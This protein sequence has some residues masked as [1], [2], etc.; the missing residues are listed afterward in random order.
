[1]TY[2]SGYQSPNTAGQSAYSPFN[3]AQAPQ[4]TP[5]GQYAGYPPAVGGDNPFP[6]QNGSTL[7]ADT[8]L[9]PSSPEEIDALSGNIDSKIAE[10]RRAFSQPTAPAVPSP[11]AP[12]GAAPI[13]QEEMNWALALENKVKTE[14][15]QPNA[16]ETAQY[17]QIYAKLQAAQAGQQA[18]QNVPGPTA[19][20]TPA[21]P[22]AAPKVSDEEISWALALEQKVNSGHQPTAEET[23]RY[24][25][26]FSRL[27]ASEQPAQAPAG[28]QA[29]A[30]P[31]SQEEMNWAL[32][33]ENKVKTEGYQPNAQETARYEQIYAKLQAAQQAA[34]TAP[35][36]PGA[37][38]APGAPATDTPRNWAQWSQPFNV[39]A[40]PTMPLPIAGPG[41]QPVVNVPTSLRG[42]PQNPPAAVLNQAPGQSNAMMA[43]AP[44][45]APSQA[46]IDWALQLEARV[47]QGH[48]PNAQ[49]TAQYQDI[50]RRLQAAQQA[51]AAPAAPAPQG[52][53][54]TAPTPQPGSPP[55]LPPGVSQQDI[56]WALQLE[57][58]VQQGHQPNAQE[59][60]RY[61]EIAQKL[62]A[63]QNAVAA[64]QQPPAPAP[65]PQQQPM[66]QPPAP[67]PAPQPAAPQGQAQG[68][69]NG[70][71]QQDI[72]WAMDLEARVNQQG[73]QPNQQEIQ[74]HADIA[75]RLQAAPAPQQAA[76]PAF[77][78]NA[79]G[80]QQVV[81]QGPQ[82]IPIMPQGYP[83]VQPQTPQMV[84]PY[85]P[86]SNSQIPLPAGPQGYA[87]G[88]MPPGGPP[89]P[90]PQAQSPGFMARLG[91]A[92]NALWE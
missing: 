33:L 9:A 22:A 90:A 71:T 18:P 28:P 40:A 77:N 11:A 35:A 88:Q 70:L 5:P 57:N 20:T 80:V 79:G 23:A 56:D 82:S 87:P 58:R 47:Q 89:P 59:M 41:G 76:P 73:Y 38:T 61:Q 48:Q 62:Q 3:R 63:A 55:P 67:V 19:S 25:S 53:Q 17:E 6:V 27:N 68:L 12:A 13:S 52:G 81:P 86:S 51:P 36:A 4:Q 30:P 31:V 46:E 69:P 64:G 65:A 15:Y 72:Q 8:Y 91:N 16:Q 37:P 21:A 1:M 10:I 44:S 60:A 39:P 29:S 75:Q 84:V 24:N 66:S 92:W 85:Q 83:Q 50:A 26:I 32:A 78:P 54:P 43:A 45:A 49:E 14:G 7:G 34:Q 74:R 42:A 2:T